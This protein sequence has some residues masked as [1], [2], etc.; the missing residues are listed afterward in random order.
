MV[1]GDGLKNTYEILAD[2]Q[3]CS[4]Q[5]SQVYYGVGPLLFSVKLKGVVYLESHT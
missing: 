3:D 2:N 1:G 4:S 5:T